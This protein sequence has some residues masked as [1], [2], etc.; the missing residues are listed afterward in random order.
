MPGSAVA[1]ALAAAALH[2]LWN[3]LLAGSRDAQA[4]AAVALPISVVAFAPV[5]AFTWDV[6]SAAAPYIAASAALELAYFAVLVKAYGRADVSLVYPIARGVAPVLVLLVASAALGAMT[7]VGQVGGVVLVAVGIVFVR[8]VSGRA[9]RIGVL[10]ALAVAACIAGY[11][12]VDKEGIRHADPVSYLV[13]TMLG[14]A[15]VYPAWFVAR[16]GR[17]SLRL[18]LRPGAAVAGVAT[19]GAYVLVLAALE[20]AP[21]AAVAAV[22]ES[23]IL[24][25]TCLSA[26]MLR[27]RV[28]LGRLAGS[29]LVV[30]GVALVALT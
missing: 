10:L 29:G 4:T 27:E 3:V 18:G 15:I 11:T 21:A 14:P 2:A 26:V 6:S 7:S 25:A 30:A 13:L 23:S 16:R 20:R 9:D 12:L 8:G 22:R 28:G 24:I 1:L 5:A 17:P 19:S